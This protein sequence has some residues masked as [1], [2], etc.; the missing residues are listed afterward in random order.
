MIDWE[1]RFDQ[2]K[3]VFG[4]T[5]NAFLASQAERVREHERALAGADGE[6]RNGVWLA[7]Q[8]LEVTAMTRPLSACGRRMTWRAGAVSAS[9]R[10]PFRWRTTTG[11]SGPSI[12]SSPSLSS[13]LARICETPSSKGCSRRWLRAAPC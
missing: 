7:E 10:K 2:G 5:P 9:R 13:S 1:A 3:Y 11:R 12:S 6:G 4:E 8:G